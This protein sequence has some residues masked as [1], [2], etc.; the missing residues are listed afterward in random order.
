[1]KKII[2]V[3]F[4]FYGC[5]LFSQVK[6]SGVISDPEGRPL[7]FIPIGLQTLPDSNIIKGTMTDE[8]GHY[9]ILVDNYGTYILQIKAIEFKEK[10]SVEIILDSLSGQIMTQ[11]FQLELDSK[12]LEEVSVSTIRRVVEFS[13]GNIIV[14]IENSPLAKGNTIYDLLSKLPG[15]SIDNN[16]I[17]LNGKSGVI[18]MID[19]R[20]QYITNTQLLNMLKS[21]NAE[22]VEKIELLKNPPVKY[23]ASGTSGMINIKTKKTKTRG[24]SGALYTSCS[25]GIY[26]RSATGLTLNYKAE[27]ISLFTD[28]NYNYGIYGENEKFDKKISYDT[29][30]TEFNSTN[31]LKDIDKG[32]NYKIGADWSINEK[33]LLGFKVEG[34]PGAYLSSGSGRNN[35]LL[36]NNLGF[37]HLNVSSYTPDKWYSSNYNVNGE[38][39]FD[40]LGS[41]ILFTSDY[42]QLTENN[43]SSI[44]N[45]FY[46]KNNQETLTANNYKSENKSSTGIFTSKLD[47]TKVYKSETSIEMGAKASIINTSNRYLFERQNSFSGLYLKDTTLSNNYLYDEHTYA[48]YFNFI[49]SF[50]KINFQ[51]GVRA[52]NTNLKG[53]NVLKNFEI[54]KNY[55]NLFPNLSVEYMPSENNS[56]QLNINRRI[57]R[58]AYDVLS[59]FQVYQDQYKYFQGNPFLLPHYSNNIELT[60]NFKELLSQSITFSRIDNIA[61]TYTKQNDS[62]KVTTE[63]IKNMKYNNYYAYSLYI[64]YSPKSWWE[65]SANGVVSYTEYSGDVEGVP[66]KTS[67]F[68]YAPSVT[69]TF[70]APKDTKIEVIALYN[71]PKNAGFV[72]IKSR[73]MVSLAI[74]KSFF[75]D[76]LD[77]S[78]GIN[79]IFYSYI[80]RSGVDFNNQNWNYSA[81]RDTRRLILAITYSFGKIKV[82]ER[83]IDSSEE[84]KERL[85]H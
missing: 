15:V 78:V 18:L 76:K 38:H 84:E 22:T 48:A 69:N 42:T 11:D 65:V 66:F 45:I 51:L 4:L 57:D 60:H 25:Q 37:D 1:M 83:E 34:G 30:T 50:D 79:D 81:S 13:N 71:S 80:G 53:S 10:R 27:K 16:T 40:T 21:M 59:P 17:Q 41:N 6:I 43:S 61:L 77:C 8:T 68:S 73:W 55:F 33:N 35:I 47:F 62:S 14:N 26:G 70:L 67:A 24:Y 54:K 72:Q 46:D 56:F 9:T 29:L 7:P 44:Q 64:Q 39:K 31:N 52:E 32:L 28:I 2:F 82:N 75:K 19:G 12:S 58:P 85:K 36:D 23:D 49:K 63:T 3:F 20:V 74:K 5:F